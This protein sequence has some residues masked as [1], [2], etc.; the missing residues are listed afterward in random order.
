MMAKRKSKKTR[1]IQIREPNG[2]ASRSEMVKQYPPTQVKR[3]R[4]AALAGMADPEWGS[5]CGQMFLQG[6]LSPPE[7]AAAKRWSERVEKYHGAI[8]APPPNPKA[9]DLDRRS[10][11]TSPDP[12]SE[13][14]LKLVRRD[15]DAI[16]DFLSAHSVL[17][18]SGKVSEATV[19]AACERNDCPVGVLEFEALQRGLLWLAE[20]WNLTNQ[21]K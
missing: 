2:R 7:Y 8:G 12:D 15:M 16:T 3:L 21:G 1:L 6:R 13:E 19:R 17:C 18:A 4:D 10:H 5:V 11:G 9:L 20:Y 14:G